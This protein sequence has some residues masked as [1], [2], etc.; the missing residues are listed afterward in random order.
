MRS[1][2]V[3]IAVENDELDWLFYPQL[4]PDTRPF[5]GQMI[6]RGDTPLAAVPHLGD[7]S[8]K[9]H[10]SFATS[11]SSKQCSES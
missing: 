8:M 9:I 2:I 3:E 11:S 4:R 7:L 5:T 6:W 1:R 10:G